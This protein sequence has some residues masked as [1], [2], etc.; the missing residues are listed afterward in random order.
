MY[1]AFN[2]GLPVFWHLP[3]IGNAEGKKLSKRDFGFSLTD[4][5]KG[6]FLPEALANYLAIIGHS[7]S[8]EIMDMSKLVIDLFQFRASFHQRV[9]FATTLKN[10]AG[11]IT[12]W[13]IRCKY[14]TCPACT[15]LLQ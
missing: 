1:H 5:R 8:E 7:V 13:I 10:S 11:L 15:S 6:G 9:K 3:I 12:K 2:V 4:L 14:K